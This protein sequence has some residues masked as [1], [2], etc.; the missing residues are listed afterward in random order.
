[1]LKQDGN[2]IFKQRK[3]FFAGS[4]AVPIIL[5]ISFI[6]RRNYFKKRFRYTGE[7]IIM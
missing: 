7:E 5:I 2:L 4:C 3:P 1:M 6:S